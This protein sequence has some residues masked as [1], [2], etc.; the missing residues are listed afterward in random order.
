LGIDP[1]DVA[2][3]F[4]VPRNAIIALIDHVRMTYGSTADDLKDKAGIG[5]NTLNDLRWQLLE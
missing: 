5:K 1:D 4:T 2:P 3:H